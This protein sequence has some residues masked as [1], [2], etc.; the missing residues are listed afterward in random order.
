MK[1]VTELLKVYLTVKIVN[2]SILLIYRLL[3]ILAVL[4]QIALIFYQAF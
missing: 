4:L 1:T 2:E 3:R